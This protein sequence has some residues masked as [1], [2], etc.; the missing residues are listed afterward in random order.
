MPIDLLIDSWKSPMQNLLRRCFLS[1]CLVSLLLLVSCGDAPNS[2]T[3]ATGNLA[4]P[5]GGA[6]NLN[7]NNTPLS[8]KAISLGTRENYGPFNFYAN[9]A[10]ESY[11][12]NSKEAFIDE[13]NIGESLHTCLLRKRESILS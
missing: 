10:A 2:T 13:S 6:T 1:I 8:E 12:G 11:A 5:A 9:L 3:L 4:V 7:P